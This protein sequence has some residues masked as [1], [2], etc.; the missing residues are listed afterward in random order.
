MRRSALGA[1]LLG[2]VLVGAVSCSSTPLCE[3]GEDEERFC[4]TLC[5]RIANAGV[6]PEYDLNPRCTE[7]CRQNCLASVSTEEKIE[8]E[9]GSC[10]GHHHWRCVAR[11]P[12]ATTMYGRDGATYVCFAFPKP[13]PLPVSQGLNSPCATC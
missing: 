12:T 10:Y 3:L 7:A 6:G 5:E 1:V 4:R 9:C 11:Q 13:D 2:G 8:T